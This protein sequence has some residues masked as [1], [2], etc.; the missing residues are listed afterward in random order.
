MLILAHLAFWCQGSFIN[1]R[2]IEREVDTWP[3]QI[4]THDMDIKT[5]QPHKVRK[6]KQEQKIVKGLTWLATSV[7]FVAAERMPRLL[8]LVS[9]FGNNMENLPLRLCT[10]GSS[11]Q[12]FLP[13]VSGEATF[14]RNTLQ[15][16]ICIQPTYV[17]QPSTYC[18][19]TLHLNG[20]F[21]QTL[22]SQ[23]VPF[24]SLH[25]NEGRKE[26]VT[27]ESQTPEKGRE[28]LILLVR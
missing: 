15:N 6:T 25:F 21:Q 23:G 18:R 14:T 19:I 11:W 9:W 7:V 5:F 17:C 28:S 2:F 4:V 12:I 10:W 8:A 22:G 1:M 16:R 24:R 3:F 13:C 20:M 26:L 27:L